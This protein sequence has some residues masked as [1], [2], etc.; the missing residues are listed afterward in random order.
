MSSGHEIPMGEDKT[1]VPISVD[2][3]LLWW[4]DSA[5][6]F[7]PYNSPGTPSAAQGATLNDAGSLSA[8]S[9]L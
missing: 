2:V 9:Y 5:F 3:F 1:L 8:R 6:S 7:G 4:S